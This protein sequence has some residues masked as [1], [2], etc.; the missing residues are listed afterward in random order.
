MTV[1]IIKNPGKPLCVFGLLNTEKGN[2]IAD[3]MLAW[4][5]P[6][7]TVHI[8]RHDGK[9]FE[10]PALRYMQELQKKTNRPCLYLH[11]KGAC[12]R[13]EL[14]EK[15]RRMWKEQFAENGKQYFDA[16]KGSKPRVAAPIFSPEGKSWYNGF[17]ANAAAMRTI[18]EIV[19]DEFRWRFE[20]LFL[21]RDDV[22][23]IGVLDTVKHSDVWLYMN[24]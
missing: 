21:N 19:P 17:V 22:E 6:H 13:D 10:Q 24:Y 20:R 15:V 8:V 1:E 14:S 5:R 9:Q 12:F 2:I 3:E 23:R 11:T 18:P 7:Y 16:V 4:L